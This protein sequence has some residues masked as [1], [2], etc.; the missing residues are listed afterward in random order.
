MEPRWAGLSGRM[1]AA[2]SWG[3]RA[4][5]LFQASAAAARAPL[6]RAESPAAGAWARRGPRASSSVTVRRRGGAAARPRP[7]RRPGQ[8]S[9]S[10]RLGRGQR[11]GRGGAAC[12][13]GPLSRRRRPG[14]LLLRRRAPPPRG[15][16]SAL[17]RPQPPP[18]AR[19]RRA[20]QPM[21]HSPGP[22]SE[23]ERHTPLQARPC[24]LLGRPLP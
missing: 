24:G 3:T 11:P 9:A 17:P 15:A 14:L 2:G 5:K 20:A 7:G 10:L 8:G 12:L 4:G 18:P 21:P 23:R 6:G 22:R 16:T 1:R 13:L 19:A